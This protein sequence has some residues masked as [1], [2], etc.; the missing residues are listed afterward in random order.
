[1]VRSVPHASW[2]SWISD[3]L[4][5]IFIP[6]LPDPNIEEAGHIVD[7]MDAALILGKREKRGVPSL[8]MSAGGGIER[9][10]EV[11]ADFRAGEAFGEILIQSHSVCSGQID[12]GGGDG[13][14]KKNG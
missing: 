13:T 14:Q 3:E 9:N 8:G 10:P 12:L 2:C 7:R 4:L 5:G 1:M 6:L 11:V